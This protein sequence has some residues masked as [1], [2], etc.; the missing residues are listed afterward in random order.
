MPEPRQIASAASHHINHMLCNLLSAAIQSKQRLI[1]RGSSAH[2]FGASAPKGPAERIDLNPS[3]EYDQ[4]GRPV[5]HLPEQMKPSDILARHDDGCA[6]D[7]GRVTI[8]RS[9]LQQNC[10]ALEVGLL[11]HRCR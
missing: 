11:K 8:S 5:F 7:R 3:P 4:P 9:S 2:R 1:C 6:Q 10:T